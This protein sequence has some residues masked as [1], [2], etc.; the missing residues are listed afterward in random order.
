MNNSKI[1]IFVSRKLMGQIQRTL[2]TSILNFWKL[3][4]N[5]R[6]AKSNLT[7]CLF[8]Y[9]FPSMGFSLNERSIA[10]LHPE[11]KK[12]ALNFAK[13]IKVDSDLPEKL[14]N[15]LASNLKRSDV[16]NS[17]KRHQKKVLNQFIDFL[18]IYKNTVKKPKSEQPIEAKKVYVQVCDRSHIQE[19][20][21]NKPSNKLAKGKIQISFIESDYIGDNKEIKKELKRIQKEFEQFEYYLL[22]ELKVRKATADM[23]KTQLKIILGWLYKEKNVNL[24]QIS[25]DKLIKFHNVNI[26]IHD[27]ENTNEYYITKGKIIHKARQDTQHTIDLLNEFFVNYAPSKR[28]K[29]IYIIAFQNLSKFLYKDVTDIYWADNYEDIPIIQRLRIFYKNLPKESKRINPELISWEEVI[30]V[31]KELRRRADTFH[32]ESLEKKITKTSLKKRPRNRNTMAKEL[33]RFII[34]GLLVL[35]PPS[36]SRVIRELQIGK[37]FKHGLFKD[38]VFIPKDKLKDSSQAK[39]YIHLQPE[40]YKT[41]A[42]YGEWLAAFPNYEFK[43]GKKFYDYLDRWIYQG[44]REWLMTD[45]DSTNNHDYLILG[46][47]NG[48]PLKAPAFGR[49]VAT[50]FKY[51]TGESVHPHKLRT[52][53][54]TYLVNKGASKAELESA[55]FWMRH[56]TETANSNYTKQTLDEKLAPG[57]AIA[58]KLNSELLGSIT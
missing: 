29:E 27:F 50:I 19:Y 12:L 16:S 6:L 41:G 47:V 1:R 32:I 45:A 8:K 35:V 44:N 56:S 14:L 57:A 4:E 9:T 23:Y 24:D 30:K 37:T 17:N 15:A 40:D 33:Q 39:Y 53:F 26:N 42:K 34:L 20:K 46:G 36:R 18:S 51:I 21:S 48:Q 11:D 43:D 58:Q 55:A 22:N 3:H 2:D 31:L 7:T 52:V 54:R 13:N 49:A 38:G 5:N 25:F 10:R 28:T